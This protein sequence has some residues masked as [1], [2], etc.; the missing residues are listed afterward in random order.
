MDNYLKQYWWKAAIILILVIVVA[1]FY[2]Q[3]KLIKGVETTV[4][5]DSI[6]INNQ[7]ILKRNTTKAQQLIKLMKK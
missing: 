4:H 6:Q 2:R 3:S 1:L 5:N 7:E